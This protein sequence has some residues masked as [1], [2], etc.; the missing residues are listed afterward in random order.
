MMAMFNDGAIC[1]IEDLRV[2]EGSILDA[3][4]EEGI[5]VTVK[6]ALSQREIGSE[7]NR[8]LVAQTAVHNEIPTIDLTQVVVSE[9]LRQWHA[10]RT[11]ALIFRD[12]HH[13]QLND[14]YKAKWAEYEKQASLAATRYF[15]IGVGVV[16]NPTVRALAPILTSISGVAPPGIFEVRVAWLNALGQEGS[17]SDGTVFNTQDGS[18]AVVDGRMQPGDGAAFN[19][20]AGPLGGTVSKQNST[21]VIRTQTWSS[22]ATGFIAGLRPMG[23]QQPDFY[24][25]KSRTSLRG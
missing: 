9:E 2:Y 20:Y 19:V 13:N 10:L 14:R 22:P 5:D 12:A 16:C 25:R 18:V 11:L 7:I 3:A 23:G 6:L 21:A 4:S 1:T 24:L 8:F 15:E 17:L